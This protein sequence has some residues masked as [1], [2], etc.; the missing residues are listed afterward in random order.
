MDSPVQL[1]VLQHQDIQYLHLTNTS[2][3]RATHPAIMQT[4]LLML[5]RNQGKLCLTDLD[6]QEFKVDLT[7]CICMKMWKVLTSS[8]FPFGTVRS[9]LSL[10]TWS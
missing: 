4:L 10:L 2:V 6:R 9:L 5:Q 1:V 7:S 3:Y 8:W